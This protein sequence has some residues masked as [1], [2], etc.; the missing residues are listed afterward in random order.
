ITADGQDTCILRAGADDLHWVAMHL[1]WIGAPIEVID[2]PELLTVIEELRDWAGSARRAPEREQAPPGPG[3]GE[4]PPGPGV[5]ERTSPWR[6]SPIALFA[7]LPRAAV[8]SGC[9]SS[10]PHEE[11]VPAPEPRGAGACARAERRGRSP[12]QRT[13]SGA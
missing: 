5:G 9:L 7:A 11:P 2:P 6:R 3:V 10:D 1:A 4:G 8:R 12:G 13:G